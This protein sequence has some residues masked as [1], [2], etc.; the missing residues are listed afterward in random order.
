MRTPTD[1][2]EFGGPLYGE[3]HQDTALSEMMR[4]LAE[5]QAPEWE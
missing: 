2:D 4:R 5:G 3:D 1:N